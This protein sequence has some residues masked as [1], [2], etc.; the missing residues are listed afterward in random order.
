MAANQLIEQVQTGAGRSNLSSVD[1]AV[2]PKG[3]LL[4]AFAG[5]AIGDGHQEDIPTFVAVPDTLDLDEAWIL[6]GVLMQEPRELFI[7]IVPIEAYVNHD[8][9]FPTAA[10]CPDAGALIL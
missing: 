5:R 3:W 10:D 1:V 2:D 7:P 4:A 9:T 6:A 8:A